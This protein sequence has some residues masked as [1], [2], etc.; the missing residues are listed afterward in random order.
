VNVMPQD[1]NLPQEEIPLYSKRWWVLSL[2]FLSTV[3]NYLDRMVLSVLIPVIRDQ[4][5]FDESVY[6]NITA[7]FQMAYT[8]GALI[9][10]YLLDTLGTK[11]GMALTVGVW[12]VATMLHASAGSP[13]Q[14][15][16]WRGLL[17]LAE[18]GNFPAATKAAAE[19]FRPQERAL[20]V[21]IF[22][23][24]TNIAAVIG[25]P[26]FIAI[27]L[28]FGWRP[29]F[30]V[31]GAMGFVWLAAWLCFYHSPA[32]GATA[33][34]AGRISLR[35][36]L[37]YRQAWGFA[38][39]KFL[40]DPVW[41]FFLFWLPLYFHDV[42]HFDM[43][44]LAWA[45]PVVYLISDVGAVSGGWFSGHLI[46]R[47]WPRGKARKTVM[48]ICALIMPVAA[49]GVLV[50]DSTIAVLLFSLATFSHQAWMTNLFTTPSDVFPKEA[51]GSVL[52][53]GGS[54]GGLGGAL[55]SSL[56]PGHVIGR[57]GYTP[58]FLAM[59]CLYMV[60]MILFHILM[61]DLKPVSFDLAASARP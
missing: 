54:L 53:L 58:L 23:A 44:Q 14:I 57:I 18:S 15:G 9:C 37:A 5:H 22:N 25:P 61:R 55:F 4:F 32:P 1:R 27:Q 19:W 7:A 35:A 8:V 41:W 30:L 20:A 48:L 26:V 47:G 11:I 24:G 29:C 33:V 52:G 40:T 34:P 31:L 59:S 17:G 3:I 6:G 49:L 43:R 2:L 13:L 45:L 50:R 51:V 36:T 12:S 46:R 38:V 39:A 42:R 16:I 21:G 28:A 56:I 10:G 60:A